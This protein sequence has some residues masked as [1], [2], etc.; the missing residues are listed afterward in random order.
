MYSVLID[1]VKMRFP[2]THYIPLKRYCKFNGYMLGIDTKNK[3][4]TKVYKPGLSTTLLKIYNNENKYEG[5]S[6]YIEIYGLN[7]HKAKYDQQ[8]DFIL[9]LILIYIDDNDLHDEVK[10]QGIDIAIDIKERPSLIKVERNRVRGRPPANINSNIYS[11]RW[12]KTH[13]LYIEG[14]K[15]KRL[16]YRNKKENE[17][18]VKLTELEEIVNCKLNRLNKQKE[19]LFYID[20]EYFYIKSNLVVL[21]NFNN[22]NS[23]PSIIKPKNVSYAYLYDKANKSSLNG[24]LSRFEIKVGTNDLNNIKG[25]YE[26]IAKVLNRYKVTVD[27]KLINF[28]DHVFISK[29]KKELSFFSSLNSNNN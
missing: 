15:Y 18:I 29:L 9:E 10:I 6:C 8:K 3:Y 24:N 16:R 13:T 5:N 12:F 1:T 22:L 14:N 4:H 20:D 19:Q 28:S 23:K 21:Y 25:L 2:A 27:G 11:D 26:A 7:T 17:T